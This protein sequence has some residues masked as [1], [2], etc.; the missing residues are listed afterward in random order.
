MN[1]ITYDGNDNENYTLLFKPKDNVHATI[2][3]ELS[4]EIMLGEDETM[5]LVSNINEAIEEYLDDSDNTI[6]IK[7]DGDCLGVIVDV[8]NNSE[9]D[10]IDTFTYWFDDYCFID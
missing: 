7:N 6:T 1:A 9:S 3:I 4:N 8:W 10:V 5:I 2:D